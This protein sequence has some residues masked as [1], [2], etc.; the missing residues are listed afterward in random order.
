MTLQELCKEFE[1][2]VSQLSILNKQYKAL[3]LPQKA[4]DRDLYPKIRDK[5]YEVSRLY[6]A[7]S[8]EKTKLWNAAQ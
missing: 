7:I 6:K 2:T 5:N 8:A 1:E 4:R 3:T